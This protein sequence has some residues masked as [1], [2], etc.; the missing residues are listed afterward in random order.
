MLCFE[1]SHFIGRERRKKGSGIVGSQLKGV[2]GN[3]QSAKRKKEWVMVGNC[4]APYWAK[5]SS[6]CNAAI[7]SYKSQLNMPYWPDMTDCST[8]IMEEK[9]T[10]GTQITNCAIWLL[11]KS[12]FGFNLNELQVRLLSSISKYISYFLTLEL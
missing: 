5:S 7:S 1:T 2:C 9:V 11:C 10:G 6:A 8:N 12:A 4:P 3:D